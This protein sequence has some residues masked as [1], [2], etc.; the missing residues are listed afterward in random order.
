[1]QLASVWLQN[2]ENTACMSGRLDSPH[3]LVAR[4]P[5]SAVTAAP[6]ACHPSAALQT[7]HTSFGPWLL[8]TAR[9]SKHP[10]LDSSSAPAMMVMHIY[11]HS[12][13]VASEEMAGCLETGV[14]HVTADRSTFSTAV[15][16]QYPDG[17]LVLSVRLLCRSVGAA[18]VLPLDVGPYAA[19]LRRRVCHLDCPFPLCGRLSGSALPERHLAEYA[20]QCA[21]E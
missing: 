1:M 17:D 11:W 18:I 19:Q 4:H 15:T 8:A 6:W 3:H 12:T 10:L 21:S 20:Q 16:A 9:P 2:R 13:S 14:P 7:R 5:F